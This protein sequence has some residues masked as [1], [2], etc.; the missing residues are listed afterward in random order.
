MCVDAGHDRT[1][2]STEP[3]ADDRVADGSSDAV[4]H[5]YLGPRSG[6]VAHSKRSAA[7]RPAMPS[8][9]IEVVPVGESADQAVWRVRP[10]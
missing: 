7:N 6:E 8:K 3:V 4:R 9:G 1:E 5:P 10:F 2:A